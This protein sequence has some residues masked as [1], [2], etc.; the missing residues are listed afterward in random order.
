MKI[1]LTKKDL[2]KRVKEILKTYAED[3]ES[4]DYIHRM[5]KR[6][7][8]GVRNVDDEKLCEMLTE[9]ESDGF[10]TKVIMKFDFLF[11]WEESIGD[12]MDMMRHFVKFNVPFV[13]T[14]QQL[15][16]EWHLEVRALLVFD[17]S[18]KRVNRYWIQTSN[19]IRR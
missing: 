16:D 15:G 1:P 5:Y 9:P 12:L 3:T 18:E 7:W 19:A 2:A 4:K 8:E 6:V 14:S 11:H 13:V 17:L 10:S